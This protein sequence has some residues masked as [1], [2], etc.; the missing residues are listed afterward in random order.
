MFSL[1]GVRC[2]FALSL[3]HTHLFGAGHA[4]AQPPNKVAEFLQVIEKS[5]VRPANFDLLD[6][7]EKL[8]FELV[9]ALHHKELKRSARL[10][11]RL[12]KLDLSSLGPAPYFYLAKNA[13]LQK[14]A[15]SCK[16]FLTQLDRMS[17]AEYHS[18]ERLHLNFTV[19]LLEQKYQD[20]L[21]LWE[22]A[23]KKP[24]L[25]QHQGKFIWQAAT[26][27]EKLRNWNKMFQMLEFL[28]GDF[29]I[30]KF[31]RQAY[32]K[33]MHYG[34]K[35]K[36]RNGKYVM[37]MAAIK[38][39]ARNASV[40]PVAKEIVLRALWGP[41]R[42]KQG[43]IKILSVQEKL[44]VLISCRLYKMSFELGVGAE[45]DKLPKA[46]SAKSRL[47]FFE[48]MG[49]ISN[50]L[51][52]YPTAR[53][54]FKLAM[55]EKPRKKDKLKILEHLADSY[56]YQGLRRQANKLYLE[57]SK[58]TQRKLFR[59]YYFWNAYLSRDLE[60]LDGIIKTK[61]RHILPARDYMQPEG[62]TYWRARTLEK[63]GQLGLAKK[64]YGSV[65]ENYEDDIY[66]YFVVHSRSYPKKPDSEGRFQP[67]YLRAWQDYQ[68]QAQ[69]NQ[70]ISGISSKVLPVL[71]LVSKYDRIGLTAE[72]KEL[73]ATIRLANM[74]RFD[75]LAIA[76]VADKVGANRVLYQVMKSYMLGLHRQ[77]QSWYTLSASRKKLTKLWQWYY[78][79]P[80]SEL[81]K[82]AADAFGV[83][84]LLVYS[85]MRNESHYREKAL[86]IVGARGLMQLM[87]YTVQ[88]IKLQLGLNQLPLASAWKPQVNALLGT[89]YLSYLME[90][91]DRTPALAVAAYNAGPKAVHAW[92]RRCRNCNL[93]EFIE[94]ISYR[95]TRRYVKRVL[96]DFE[97]Y[98]MIYPVEARVN[99]FAKKIPL[100]R[101]NNQL[102]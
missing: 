8:L 22:K 48:S 75:S 71:G 92:L 81:V 76:E 96:R 31:S 38:N 49:V 18:I 93:D 2:F 24:S 20:F 32:L 68:K 39:I 100:I 97:R 62:A 91:F 65:I 66:A 5:P 46:W 21:T 101:E 102:F 98:Q 27:Y 43:K 19:L 34:Q 4:L 52:R 37:S 26:Q 50:R 29:P 74:K 47:K 94:S 6:E 60:A 23:W 9:Q 17:L 15:S 1:C 44:D 95:E 79:R 59:W 57:A 55:A 99:F 10:A 69:E 82:K 77:Q 88:K 73:L 14:D 12:A 89:W 13:C 67:K 86:S 61:S 72:A 58:I 11:S 70:L 53:K 84:P 83:S 30:T 85:V 80:E 28:V 16:Q 90:H 45:R 40:S 51:Y 41:V 56:R 64:L 33:L 7:S 54:Y 25:R 63:N 3:L 35:K 36:L 87:P 42:N 78:P